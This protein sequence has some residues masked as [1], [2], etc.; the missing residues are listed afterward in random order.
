M[1]CSI[2]IIILWHHNENDEFISRL[3]RLLSN[4][5]LIFMLNEKFV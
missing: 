5:N 3:E 4:I 1:F 2:N